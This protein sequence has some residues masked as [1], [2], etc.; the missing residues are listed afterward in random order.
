MRETY[1]RERDANLTT[2]NEIRA[3]IGL[4]YLA[5]IYHVN[6]T[7]RDDVWQRNGYGIEHLVSQQR[8]KFL[9]RCTVV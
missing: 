8:F 5:G 9:L 3:L 4:L 1:S 2:V 6:R 7:K